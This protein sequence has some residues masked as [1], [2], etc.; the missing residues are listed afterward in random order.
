MD[1]A[2]C[3]IDFEKNTLQYS[4]ANNPLWIL[5]EISESE[6]VEAREVANETH[7]IKEYKAT[8]QPVG[9]F[10]LREKF[11]TQNL[12][13]NKGDIV[14]VFTDGFADQFGGVRG[15]KFKY[16]PFKKLILDN[17]NL[18]MEV[19][20]DVIQDSFTTWKGELEQIDD[21]CIIGVRI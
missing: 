14:Y 21:V 12:A 10:P 5:K 19:Q 3:A 4:G 17:Q 13:L 2:L 18:E 11:G 20:K 7:I 15:K 1:I 8:K 16:K 6:V 9:N